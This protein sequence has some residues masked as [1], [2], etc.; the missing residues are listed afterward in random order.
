MKKYKVRKNSIAYFSMEIL[1][2][3][4]VIIFIILV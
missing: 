3:L 1:K 4:G 2:G